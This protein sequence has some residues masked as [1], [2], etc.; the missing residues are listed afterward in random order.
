[1]P[2]HR[3]GREH[4][5]RA[6]GVAGERR[7]GAL[8]PRRE[9]A[10]APQPQGLRPRPLAAQRHRRRSRSWCRAAAGASCGTTPRSRAS[11]ICASSRR[12]RPSASSTRTASAAASP[13]RTTAARDFEHLVG[14]RVDPQHRHRALEQGDEGRTSSIHPGLPA[15][16]PA[17][18]R[19]EGE[20][21]P[22]RHRR[23]HLPD[24]LQQ[25]HQAVGRRPAGHRPL[26][27][28]LAALEG[29]GQGAARGQAPLHAAARVD[30]RTRAWRRC[31]CCGRRRV[32]AS[33]Q[34]DLAVVRGRRRH[35]LL[36]RLR[37]R[38]RH[39]WSPATAASPGQAPM[40][41]ALGL[42]A[43][44]EPAA[45]RD[46]AAEPRRGRRLPLAR[47]PLRQHRAGLVLLEGGQPGA[48]TSSTRR[49]SPIPTGGSRPS[50]TS[51]RG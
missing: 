36:L 39:A 28:G 5:P 7:R 32:D 40:M 21:E 19:W 49:A 43:V 6:P 4:V 14:E 2:A 50:T 10:R 31:S 45:L 37:S 16:G 23:L 24:L 25:R 8:R 3:A 41:P 34:H 20:V 13:A 12:S 38:A 46:R 48:R 22:R 17:S 26:A 29:R 47:H 27:A 42:R 30:A 35:R 18:V 1:M 51:T 33:A 44:A 11:A 15:R 9:P